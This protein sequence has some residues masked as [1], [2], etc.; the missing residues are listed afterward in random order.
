MIKK[1]K[2]KSEKPDKPETPELQEVENKEALEQE[3]GWEA[4]LEK[5]LA[6]K[7][8]MY[9]EYVD[10]YERLFAE[11]DNFRKRTA[12]EKSVMYDLG[13]KETV[14]KILSVVDNLE[15]ALESSSDKESDVY[16]GV[17]MTLKNL[18]Q[19]LE[20]LSVKTIPALGEKFDP[21]LH[22]AVSHEENED[23]GENIITAELQKG[24][25]YKDSVIRHSM[26]KVA[27]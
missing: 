18:H 6:E 22:N 27:N 5:A 4:E 13:I 17:E 26:V 19:T 25:I 24:Y 21:N 7:E 15:R 12:K 3:S 10:K 16:K 14:S 11:F 2:K 1:D 23:Y 8:K 20:S 9:L